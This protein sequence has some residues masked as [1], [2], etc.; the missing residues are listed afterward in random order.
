MAQ[1][2]QQSR[3]FSAL[4]RPQG[5]TGQC[6]ISCVHVCTAQKMAGSAQKQHQTHPTPQLGPHWAGPR[7]TVQ[8][9][10]ETDPATGQVQRI[11]PAVLQLS[12]QQSRLCS[13][14]ARFP[15]LCLPTAVQ[16][17]RG[18]LPPMFG[19]SLAAAGSSLAPWPCNTCI[20]ENAMQHVSAV[21]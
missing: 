17:W 9:N 12:M 8:Y 20:Q 16:A 11:K 10:G 6:C 21:F 7:C 5:C 18:P 3:H 4:A 19:A 14:H 13:F 1:H 15:L 2:M